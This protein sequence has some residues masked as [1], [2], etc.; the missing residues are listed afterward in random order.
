MYSNGIEAMLFDDPK[1]LDE[2]SYRYSKKTIE[3]CDWLL[4]VKTKGGNNKE[5]QI[6]PRYLKHLYMVFH[7]PL[8][9]CQHGLKGLH[10]A[11]RNHHCDRRCPCIHSHS[12]CSSRG[13]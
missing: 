1:F 8:L 4:S 13:Y 7:L 6:E 10:N 2:I 3:V 5:H 11:E 12:C 9:L